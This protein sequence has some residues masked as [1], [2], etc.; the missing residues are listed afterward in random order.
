[1]VE[2]QNPQLKTYNISNWIIRLRHIKKIRN[3]HYDATAQAEAQKLANELAHSVRH[4][5]WV[6]SR[7][8][9]QNNPLSTQSSRDESLSSGGSSAPQSASIM[10]EPEHLVRLAFPDF[11]D[12][13][14]DLSNQSQSAIFERNFNL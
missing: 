2:L 7:G 8:P 1:M 3:R 10:G 12:Y 13:T 14:E 11:I 4:S 9:F 5:S 6:G